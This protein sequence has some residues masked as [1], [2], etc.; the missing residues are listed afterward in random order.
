MTALGMGG[1][2]SDR[3]LCFNQQGFPMRAAAA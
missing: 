3:G 2:V 1:D